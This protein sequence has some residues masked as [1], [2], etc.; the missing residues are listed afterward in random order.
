MAK[1]M[2]IFSVWFE[3]SVV[4]VLDIMD[5][6]TAATEAVEFRASVS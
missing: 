2:A 3:M 6:T 1:D 4:P 5:S